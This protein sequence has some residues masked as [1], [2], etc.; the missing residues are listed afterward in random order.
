MTISLISTDLFELG[1]FILV[2]FDQKNIRRLTAIHLLFFF[3]MPPK[4]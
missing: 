2:D 1:G 3:Q 4:E